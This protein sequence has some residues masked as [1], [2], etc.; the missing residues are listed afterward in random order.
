MAFDANALF[1]TG[2]NRRKKRYVLLLLSSKGADARDI[3]TIE[4]A[5]QVNLPEHTLIRLEDPEEGLKVLLVKNV[6][7]VIID[8]SFFNDDALS[9]EY[10][11][12]AKKRKKVPIFFVAK[13]ES[14]LIGEY[15]RLMF[16]YEELDDYVLAPVDFV[17]IGR[18]L[19]RAVTMDA[20]AARRFSV[21]QPVRIE[22]IDASSKE[23]VGTLVDVSLVGFGLDVDTEGMFRRGE[24]VR[25]WIPL[26]AFGIFH[27]Q[28]GEFLKVAGK[29]RRLSIDGKN[30][31]CSVE[32]LTPMQ[33]DCLAALLE[34][35]AR[36]I[37]QQRL[38]SARKPSLAPNSNSG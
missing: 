12:E 38:A 19:K 16:M 13:N 30:V 24:Q 29:V 15:R 6:E 4:R 31:G 32:H 18:K 5:V 34:Q 33:N 1:Q 23:C 7:H 3:R 26:S 11:L 17:E 35:V 14:T 22:R 20:R 21:N 9:I 8:V 36:R 27:P 37:R 2:S 28:Y 25:V 10:G